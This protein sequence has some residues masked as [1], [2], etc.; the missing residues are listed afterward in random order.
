MS[1]RPACLVCRV[2]LLQVYT[3]EQDTTFP[4][5]Y[6]P[7]KKKKKMPTPTVVTALVKRFPFLKE[8]RGRAVA[9]SVFCFLL[10]LLVRCLYRYIRPAGLS[11]DGKRLTGRIGSS[12][13]SRDKKK[14]SSGSS[15]DKSSSSSSST[16]KKKKLDPTLPTVLLLVGIHGSGK[17]FWASRYVAMVHKSYVVLSSD[18]IRSR[19]T[20]TIENYSR[21]AEVEAEVLKELQQALELRRSCILDD[22]QHNLSAEFR[23][24]VKAVA[25]QQKANCVAKMF[26]VKPSYAMARIQGAVEEGMVRYVPTMVELERQVQELAAFEKTFKEDGWVES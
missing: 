22:C 7:K 24:K 1:R 4:G 8:Q 16:A 20:G 14:H 26:T 21:E 11:R 17:S 2:A 10:A 25:M 12:R 6:R 13:V 5:A 15:H 19:L 3:H 18:T 23:A 9:I